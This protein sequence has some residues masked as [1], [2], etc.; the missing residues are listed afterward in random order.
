MLG[1]GKADGVSN[2]FRKSLAAYLCFI[3]VLGVHYKVCFTE[4]KI[5]TVLTVF[6]PDA[7]IRR[8]MIATG[9]K[10]RVLGLVSSL[11]FC[12]KINNVLRN[13]GPI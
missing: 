5:P 9:L 11:T 13:A 10:A 1:I 4:S 7:Q 8:E 6:G 3:G 12:S 2:Q